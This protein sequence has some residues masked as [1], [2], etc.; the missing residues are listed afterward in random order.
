LIQL[1]VPERA[2]AHYQLATLLNKRGDLAEARR[3][4]LM[5]LEETPR[6]RAALRLLLELS[7]ARSDNIQEPSSV[8]AVLPPK[9]TKESIP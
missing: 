1:D 6:Y 9:K 4:T 3:H 5:A 7:R 8:E 2:D